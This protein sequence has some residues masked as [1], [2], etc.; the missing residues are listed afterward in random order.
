MVTNISETWKGEHLTTR[1]LL[2]SALAWLAV[3]A[4]AGLI[5]AGLYMGIASLN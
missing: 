2:E 3:L 4:V 1:R 5:F